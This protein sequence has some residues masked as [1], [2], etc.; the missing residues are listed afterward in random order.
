MSFEN[1]A[2]DTK[3]FLDFRNQKSSKLERIKKKKSPAEGFASQ[4]QCCSTFP[5]LSFLFLSSEDAAVFMNTCIFASRPNVLRPLENKCSPAC[6]WPMAFQAGKHRIKPQ[7]YISFSW[8]KSHCNEWG[9]LGKR[10]QLGFICA[11]LQFYHLLL[12]QAEWQSN[13]KCP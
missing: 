7:S 5:I 3:G 11:K 4:L 9:S 10:Q 8:R 6:C 12:C 13:K 2:E 1:A